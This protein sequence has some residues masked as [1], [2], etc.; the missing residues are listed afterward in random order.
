MGKLII[1]AQWYLKEIM[2]YNISVTYGSK[3][4]N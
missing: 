3:S 2:L 1:I 4:P